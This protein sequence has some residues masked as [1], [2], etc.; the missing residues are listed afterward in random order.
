MQCHLPAVHITSR[1]H[2]HRAS[3]SV[4]KNGASPLPFPCHMPC[5][6]QLARRVPAAQEPDIAYEG[7][8][9]RP[10]FGHE[11]YFQPFEEA[12]LAL[13]HPLGALVKAQQGQC[14]CSHGDRQAS[15]CLAHSPRLPTWA[16]N[17][18]CINSCAAYACWSTHRVG[19]PR[20]PQRLP[21]Q[22]A[23]T[24]ELSLPQPWFVAWQSLG[25]CHDMQ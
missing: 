4:S 20:L 10:A 18:A 17:C 19:S 5:L 15:V 1:P 21:Q 14:F 16:T 6:G 22:G 12:A 3:M 7:L 13:H 2:T 9:K 11:L 8:A 25:Q 23:C 24:P